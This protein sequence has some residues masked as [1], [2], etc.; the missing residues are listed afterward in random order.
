VILAAL[1]IA[2]V[3]RRRQAAVQ[4]TAQ[5]QEHEQH[6]HPPVA[7]S[8]QLPITGSGS[9]NAPLL[10]HQ[11]SP[12]V[13]ERTSTSS[14]SIVTLLLCG[15]NREGQAKSWQARH[16]HSLHT[17]PSPGLRSVEGLTLVKR[18]LS[19]VLG[20]CGIADAASTST[21]G[22]P[23]GASL[24]QLSDHSRARQ[25]RIETM[26]RV[27]SDET[28]AAP[29]SAHQLSQVRALHTCYKCSSIHTCLAFV[30]QLRQ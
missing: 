13:C 15:A 9:V 29:N 27:G 6:H 17:P 22:Q 8:R 24:L 10:S 28:D 5:Q 20:A 26:D 18:A 7:G 1:L 30:L 11:H 14:S 16:H 19:A 23:P 2:L 3:T 4:D 25:N 21:H 12:G